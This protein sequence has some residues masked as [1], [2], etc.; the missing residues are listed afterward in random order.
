MESPTPNVVE[1]FIGGVSTLS[2]T[3]ETSPVLNALTQKKVWDFASASEDDVDR[4]L[5][6]A[7][8]AFPMWE[9]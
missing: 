5:E 4:A 2:S 9:R 1:L 3:G 7:Q 8:A 6:A